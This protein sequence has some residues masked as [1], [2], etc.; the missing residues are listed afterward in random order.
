M[1]IHLSIKQKCSYTIK[2]L[3]LKVKNDFYQWKLYETFQ[4]AITVDLWES[5]VKQMYLTLQLTEKSTY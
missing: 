1:E 2:Y 4:E 3:A 5:F